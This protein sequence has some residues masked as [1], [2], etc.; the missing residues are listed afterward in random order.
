MANFFTCAVQLQQTLSHLSSRLLPI[1]SH[2]RLQVL[3]EFIMNET[4]S[5]HEQ[6]SSWLRVRGFPWCFHTNP[7]IWDLRFSQ[8]WTYKTRYSGLWHVV[9]LEDTIILEDLA[10]SICRVKSPYCNPTQH[11]NQ[12]DLYFQHWGSMLTKA[13]P[14]PFEFT[15]GRWGSSVSSD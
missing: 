14:L 1:K 11:H 15:Q 12:E 2:I 9:L 5:L 8:W 6:Q 13:K 3:H 10:A 4:D 7:R